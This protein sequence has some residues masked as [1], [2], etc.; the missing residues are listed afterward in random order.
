[1]KKIIISI[2]LLVFIA[3]GVFA[4]RTVNLEEKINNNQKLSIELEFADKIDVKTWSG[5]RIKITA[6]VNIYDNKYNDK[7]K[8]NIKKSSDELIIESEID[9]FNKLLKIAR[10]ENK[11]FNIHCDFEVSIPA[12]IS[13]D[14]STING[15]IDMTGNYGS[16][17]LKSIS[18]DIEL[19]GNFDELD[20]NSV[21]GY[22]D[23][24]VNKNIK[25]D[26][27]MTTIT[28]DVYSDLEFEKSTGKSKHWVVGS[29]IQKS[30][31]GGGKDIKL[32]T[33]SGDIY[34]REAK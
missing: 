21:S 34:L 31:N 23:L 16:L 5:D 10:K 12:G 14:L 1:M 20:M 22:I 4:Q 8:F 30:Y 32:V 7:F 13:T 18:G 11:N 29:N 28:G 17:D 3:G 24:S 27:R 6:T 19:K 15:N 2:F 33:V 9:D 26:F 25:A